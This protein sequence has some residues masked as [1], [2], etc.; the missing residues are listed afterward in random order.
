MPS[1]A[2][3]QL[4]LESTVIDR[5]GRQRRS[6][7]AVLSP[8]VP[9]SDDQLPIEMMPSFVYRLG[10]MH[11]FCQGTRWDSVVSIYPRQ[12]R[13]FGLLNFGPRVA[14]GTAD[15]FDTN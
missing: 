5:R 14:D 11:T 10:S 6:P 13:S 9:S 2:S 15:L 4:E 7:G 3:R 12:S 1:G 8:A